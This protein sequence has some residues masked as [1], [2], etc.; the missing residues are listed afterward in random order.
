M[1]TRKNG[2]DNEPRIFVINCQQHEVE[3]Y[4]IRA[5]FHFKKTNML[6]ILDD[7]AAPLRKT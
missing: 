1:A 2:M 6:I 4:L 7:C 5:S 3:A